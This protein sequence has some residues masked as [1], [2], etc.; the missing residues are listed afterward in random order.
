[1]TLRVALV[2][3]P[4][5]DRLYGMFG[6]GEVD[7]VVHA[8]HPTL[9]RQVAEILGSG[10]RID[11][12]STHSKYAPSQ[13]EWLHPL[14]ELVAGSTIAALAPRA[15]ELCRFEGI[16]WCLPRLI[17]VR[18]LW[19]RT[20]RM[21]SIPDTWDELVESGVV[22]GFPGQES[23]LFG[24]FF[25]LVVGQGGELFDSVGKAT[26]DTPES[27]RAIETLCRLAA[28]APA[29]LA[30]WH[31]DEVD[32]AL[33]EGRIDA[34]GVWPGGWGAIRDGVLS[35]RLCPY[36]Y[37]SGR[38]R[39]VAYAGCH[40]WAIPRTCG[41][42]E[43]ALRLL[44]RLLGPEAQGLDAEGGSICAHQTALATMEPASELD[45]R[46]LD[47]TRT[48]IDEAM[49]TYPPLVRFT[50]IEDAGWRALQTALLGRCSPGEAARAIQDAA[51][52]ALV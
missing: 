32:D 30:R 39:R 2:G 35:D 27:R 50:E 18:V 42:L 45:R 12:V 3:G 43:G 28:R 41:D 8:D 11:L 44:D 19:A 16:S 48:M 7:V 49:I 47:I 52:R 14:D 22:F 4:M 24:T 36:A 17:D 51:D 23:G 40:A 25:E 13:V 33:L 21:D 10:G 5:Y 26:I 15:V 34:A 31:Y 20:D 37:P 46:R 29:D 38:S 6:P 1:M 9:N